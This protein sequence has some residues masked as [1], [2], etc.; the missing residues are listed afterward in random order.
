MNNDSSD[1]IP[2]ET[3][4]RIYAMDTLPPHSFINGTKIFEV[5]VTC[6]LCRK[7]VPAKN[8]KGSWRDNSAGSV[9]MDGYAICERCYL[10][11]PLPDARYSD[12]GTCMVRDDDG[13]WRRDRWLD[14][15]SP[16][17]KFLGAVLRLVRR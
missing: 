7:P 17:Q 11:A 4:D 10:V 16:M 1:L 5:E 6:T 8:V 15:P 2:Q 13:T 3:V 12:D 9:S 14:E